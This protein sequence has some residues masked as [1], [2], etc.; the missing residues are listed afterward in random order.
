MPAP[1]RPAAPTI[2]DVKKQIQTAIA[3]REAAIK[4]KLAAVD[5]HKSDGTKAM[6]AFA[7]EVEKSKTNPKKLQELIDEHHSYVVRDEPTLHALE[8]ELENAERQ[9]A[10]LDQQLKDMAD[11]AD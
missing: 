9:K 7:S 5:K 2:K 4:Q 3:A 10:A 11:I 1:H 8:S 6:L